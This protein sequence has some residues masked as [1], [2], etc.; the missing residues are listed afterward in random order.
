[1]CYDLTAAENIGIGRIEHF[2]DCAAI[3]VAARNAEIAEVIDGL[4]RGYNTLLSRY[5]HDDADEVGVSLSGGQW[6]RIALARSLLRAGSDLLILDEASAHLGADAEHRLQR[7]LA[8]LREGRTSLL[9]SHRL[10]TLREAGTIAVVV[11]GRVT[12][13]GSHG[14]LMNRDGEYARLFKLQAAGY[15]QAT[16]ASR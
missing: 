2:S 13:A 15:Q 12:E 8:H 11:D 7:T 14:D 16:G 10:A 3:A 4:P 6:Q 5:L 9:I 1:M